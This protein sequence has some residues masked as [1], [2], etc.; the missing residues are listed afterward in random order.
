MTLEPSLLILGV[1]AGVG[2]GLAGA[3]DPGDVDAAGAVY[4]GRVK[5]VNTRNAVKHGFIPFDNLAQQGETVLKKVTGM[6]L[7]LTPIHYNPTRENCYRCRNADCEFRW[8][9]DT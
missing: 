8:D 6:A 1:C 5:L 2:V 3:V 7:G 4:R 9:L